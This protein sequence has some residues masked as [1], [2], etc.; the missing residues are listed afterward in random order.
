MKVPNLNKF[1]LSLYKT[2]GFFVLM[3]MVS[4]IVIYAFMLFFYTVNRSWIAPLELSPSQEKVLSYQPQIV[5]LE[6]NYSKQLIEKSTAEDS[7]VA[8]ET[9]IKELDLLI[10]KSKPATQ[11]ELVQLTSTSSELGAAI[12]AKQH[13]LKNSSQ[14]V[15]NIKALLAN[16]DAELKANLITADVAASR[17]IMLQQ[18]VSSISDSQAQLVGLKDTYSRQKMAISTFKG[19][20]SSL[21]TIESEKQINDL[22]ALKTQLVVQ[23]NAA[24]STAASMKITADES[25]RVLNVAKLSPYYKALKETVPV[26]F[27][28][29][30]NMPNIEIGAPVYDCLLQVFICSKVGSVSQVYSAEEYARHPVFKTDIK[31]QLVGLKIEDKQAS[32]SKI[33]F[34]GGRPLFI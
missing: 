2:L 27:V 19:G 13:D 12:A 1:Y 25:L 7:I 15:S 34:V 6:A 9:Q 17:K 21:S 31:G 20:S 22:V 10:Q 29:Y 33:L 5:N 32:K 16:V 26:A 8:L 28:A 11:S 14:T 4:G 18:A 23:L 24:K 3:A 30:D